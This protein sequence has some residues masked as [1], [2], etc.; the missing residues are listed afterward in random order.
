MFCMGEK[1]G[2]NF[3]RTEPTIQT[4]KYL[5]SATNRSIHEVILLPAS[6]SIS[7]RLLMLRALSG[8]RQ[9]VINLAESDDTRLM[10]SALDSEEAVRNIGHAGTAMR[11]L[12]AYFSVIQGEVVLTGSDRMK[13]RPIAELVDALRKLGADIRYTENEGFPPLAIRGGL[14]KG[15]SLK[16]NGSISSQFIS[17][18][19]MI[20]PL[21]PGGLEII[22][23]G[24]VVSASYIRMTISLMETFGVRVENEGNRI[25]ISEGTYRL[26]PYTVESDWSAAAFWYAI[27]L[28]S[29][30]S[31]I[32]LPFLYAGSLQ[33]DAALVDI[34][35]RLGIVTEFGPEGIILSKK[36]QRLPEHFTQDFTECPDLVQA[37]AAALCAKGIA[38]HLTGTRTLRIKETDRIAA[39][40][41][42]LGKL[43]FLITSDPEGNFLAWEGDRLPPV[44]DPLI[45]TYHDHRM[46]MAFA[47]LAL[48]F[49]GIS[50]DDPMVVS[51]SYPG[52]WSDLEKAGF[53]TTE[54]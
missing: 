15:S 44:T 5:I 21:L 36:D 29:G 32:G 40:Q 20:G 14:L 54:V 3:Q 31:Q 51:K 33:G 27:M 13:Q 34:F 39:L 49:Q 37:V 10:L 23:E 12:T 28:L 11:F 30:D 42:E 47:P 35:S 16:V 38:F 4:V 25:F 17:A 6:K 24:A 48:V 53:R 9:E 46:A 41:Q 26:H 7:N 1:T 50:I 22:L 45:K 19:L 2:L 8:S 43:G 18:L 52:F